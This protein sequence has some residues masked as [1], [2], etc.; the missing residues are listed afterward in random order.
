MR[1][2]NAERDSA[3]C[4]P[5]GETVRVRWSQG[6]DIAN[7]TDS[8]GPFSSVGVVGVMFL[9]FHGTRRA[10]NRLIVVIW[11]SHSGKQCLQRRA[12]RAVQVVLTG[13]D[14]RI[15]SPLLTIS[16]APPVPLLPH[17]SSLTVSPH[18]FIDPF[19]PA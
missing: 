18:T 5:S 1:V 13:E 12:Q 14:I 10:G 4:E 15:M 3:P 2:I 6:S 19:D 16:T 17:T 9:V 7:T 8:Q 11:R